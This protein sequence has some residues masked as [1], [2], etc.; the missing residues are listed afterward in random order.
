MLGSNFE[1]PNSFK[2]YRCYLVRFSFVRLSRVI[3]FTC[4]ERQVRLLLV[5]MAFVLQ[6]LF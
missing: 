2:R 6:R 4:L 5:A 3:L 1:I